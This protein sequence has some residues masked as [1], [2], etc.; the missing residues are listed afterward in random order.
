MQEKDINRALEQADKA[1]ETA[2]ASAYK[3]AT[4]RDELIAEL[5]EII[6]ENGGEPCIRTGEEKFKDL[7]LD[8]FGATMLFLELDE[9]YAY[10]G[11]S[12]GKDTQA[13]F[14]EQINFDTFIVNDIID[15]ILCT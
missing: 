4:T 7:D 10:F 8:S 6:E 15:E 12:K 13:N 3:K 5:N 11:E 9:R 2:S 14:M 1:M